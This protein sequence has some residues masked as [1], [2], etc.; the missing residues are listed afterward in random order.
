MAAP[1]GAP[2]SLSSWLRSKPQ[3][4]G[5]A[6]RLLFRF[7]ESRLLRWRGRHSFGDCRSFVKCRAFGHHRP[8]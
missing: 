7:Y 8:G 6:I 2:S 3:R 1:I 4:K 5:P